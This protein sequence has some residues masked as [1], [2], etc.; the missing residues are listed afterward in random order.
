MQDLSGRKLGNYEL[1]ERLG[2]GGMAEVYKA[3]QPGM[4]RFVAVKVMLGHLATDE[5]FIERFKREAQAVGKLRHPNIVQIF[6]FGIEDDVYYMAMEFLDSGTLKEYLHSKGKLSPQEAL[7]IM[8]QLSAALDYAH[9]AGMIH[10][11]LKPANVMFTDKTYKQSILTDFGI[12]RI[13]GAAGLTG[14]GMAVGTP[15]YMAP[16]AGRGEETDGRVDIYALGV[17][18]YEMLTGQ[19]PYDADTPLAVIMKHINAPLPSFADTDEMP[20]VIERLVLKCMA[21]DPDERYQTAGELHKAVQNAV[22]EMEHQA[23]T[24]EVESQQPSTR[25]SLPQTID[26]DAPT[27]G[28]MPD[29][30]TERL[31]NVSQNR[32][33]YSPILAVGVIV[34]IVIIIGA[35]IALNS[36]GDGMSDQEATATII[37][38]QA[39][40]TDV[41]MAE[42]QETQTTA[43]EIV[44]ST[45]LA[46]HTQA[47][48]TVTVIAEAQETQTTAAEIVESTRLA[49]HTQAV[50]TVTVIAEAQGTQTAAAVQAEEQ[51][52][53][54]I[55]MMPPH[56]DNL[57]PLTHISPIMDEVDVLFLEN[58][59]EQAIEMLNGLLE[60][61]PDNV[62]ALFA[63]S[64]LFALD[65]D[66]ENTARQDAERIIELEPDS[67]LGYLALSDSWLNYPEHDPALALEAII[68]AYELNPENPHAL[69]R[70]AV[71]DDENWELQVE[72]IY[73]AEEMGANGFRFIYHMGNFLYWEE[74]Y[75]H[76]L[77]YLEVSANGNPDYWITQESFWMLLGAMMRTEQSQAALDLL[78][79]RGIMETNTEADIFVD[80][81][82]VAYRAENYGLAREWADTARVLSDEAYG[83][84]YVVGLMAWRADEDVDGAMEMLNSLEEVEVYTWYLNW[85]F[86]HNLNLDRARI[87]AEAGRFP[88]ALEFYNRVVEIDDYLDWLYEERANVHLELGNIDE[89]RSDLQRAFEITEDDDYRAHLRQRLLDVGADSDGG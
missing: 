63:R 85:E 31:P 89:A 59:R 65:W 39:A 52:V 41:A 53:E 86:G 25:V 83:A 18:L 10:R 74:D 19:A 45:R 36:D 48:E 6:D 40:E 24:K 32:Q 79:E 2:R 33:K 50:E 37:A 16:E 5:S 12:A 21:K 82:Y 64:Q 22:T 88:E 8:E 51:A 70:I 15:S 17:I 76:A 55:A 61:N 35:F 58:N 7:R 9:Q 84:T 47:V 44:E 75:P 11:D 43:A 4:D 28:S 81:A 30:H 49:A 1:R 71:L 42:A 20:E 73:A 57:D 54:G 14:T 26:E 62:D 69:W 80:A 34:A 29:H 23:V 67:P 13:L 38:Q 72:R 87:L 66:E 77:P 60:E 78:A 68:R 46:A 56:P 27:L 3:Y